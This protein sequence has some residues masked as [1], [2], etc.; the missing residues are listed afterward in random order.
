MPAWK[1]PLSFVADVWDEDTGSLH[2][3]AP[4]VYGHSSVPEMDLLT[5]FRLGWER[6]LSCRPGR[7]GPH[8]GRP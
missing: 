8:G 6:D 2:G 7:G 4:T 5:G 3:W 1:Y